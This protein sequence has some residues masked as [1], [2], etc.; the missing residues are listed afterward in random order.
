MRERE[1]GKERVRERERE[2]EKEESVISKDKAHTKEGS[3]RARLMCVREW[4][5]L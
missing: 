3:K 4:E 2:R 1:R 5:C